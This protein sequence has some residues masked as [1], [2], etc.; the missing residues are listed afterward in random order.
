MGITASV[1]GANAVWQLHV[2]VV[3][4][5]RLRVNQYKIRLSS[6]QAVEDGQHKDNSYGHPSENRCVRLK[7]IHG[8]FLLPSV[9]V[10]SGLACCIPCLS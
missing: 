8:V 10:E 5:G 3:F 2:H 7:V 1:L 9:D 4:N 6:G